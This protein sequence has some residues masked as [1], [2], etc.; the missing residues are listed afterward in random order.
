MSRRKVHDDDRGM[1][2]VARVREVREHD[3]RVGL[4]Q[5]LTAQQAREARLARM[6]EDLAS[7][8]PFD[9]GTGAAFLAARATLGALA[10][11]AADARAEAES[12]L[13]VT[14]AA[15]QH[16][17]A[18]K[19]RLTAVEKLLERRADERRAEAARQEAARLDEAAGQL[20]QRAQE[21][22]RTPRTPHSSPHPPAT[23]GTAS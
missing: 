1:A 5:A 17:L 2:A 16:W 19:S 13:T 10:A 6:E 4:Q 15:R 11:S 18:D 7:A 9:R 23:E 14:E 22:R 21:A 3:S 8:P 12:G 20:W